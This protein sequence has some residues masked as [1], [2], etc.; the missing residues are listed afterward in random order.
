M[1]QNDRTRHSFSCRRPT[2]RRHCSGRSVDNFTNSWNP[3][4]F[5]FHR[6]FRPLLALGWATCTFPG[7]LVWSHSF[8]F[9]PTHPFCRLVLVRTG[10]PTAV[11]GFS[12]F[13][14]HHLLYLSLLYCYI[15]SLTQLLYHIKISMLSSPLPSILGTTGYL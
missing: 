9:I 12:R 1:A 3:F 7:T 6:P 15:H 13:P 5:P 10:I 4:V 2:T 8:I 14:S 11:V